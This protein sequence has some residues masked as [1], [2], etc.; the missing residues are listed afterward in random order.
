MKKLSIAV[1][2]LISLVLFNA[3]SAADVVR[4][5]G[6]GGPLPAVREAAA[7]FEKKTGVKVEVTGGPTDKWIANARQDADVIY[8]GS[9][10]MMTDFV[11]AMN[12]AIDNRDVYPLY[13]R[14]LA[15]LVRP[16]NPKKIRKFTDLTKPGIKVL[17]VNGAGQNGVW[18]DAA[19]RLG[20]IRTVR[21]LRDNIV[22]YAR[23][24]AEAKDY[25]TKNPDT[26]VWLIWNI[27]QLA[28]PK[29][30]DAIPIEPQYLI[31]RDTAIAL[32]AKGKTNRAAIDFTAFLKSADGKA[33]YKKWGWITD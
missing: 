8:S 15:M 12:G 9:E 1:F 3:V 33:I 22:F 26:D 27:W 4:V 10:T 13:L 31:Y 32:T 20:N 16:G 29:L 18:E 6:P 28:N 23:N 11:Y 19:G 25:W 7:T 17:V 24:S 14:P 5:Y 2:T 21:A 30:A